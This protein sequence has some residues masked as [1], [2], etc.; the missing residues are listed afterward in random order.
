[1]SL[2][3]T[4]WIT[5]WVEIVL[6]Q[7]LVSLRGPMSGF[8]PAAF[9]ALGIAT[10]IT[11]AVIELCTMLL[12]NTLAPKSNTT[13]VFAGVI[14]FTGYLILSCSAFDWVPNIYHIP[15]EPY[16]DVLAFNLLGGY[17]TYRRARK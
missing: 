15:R 1:M 9:I 7:Y 17:V 4:L 10:V 16:F 11:L 13:R 12:G 3:A 2:R 8:H 5:Y 14:L 6:C